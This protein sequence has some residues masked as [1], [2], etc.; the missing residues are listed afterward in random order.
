[1]SRRAFGNLARNSLTVAPPLLHRNVPRPAFTSRPLTTA[2]SLPL[3]ILTNV[4]VPQ[5][6]PRDKLIAMKTQDLQ[7]SLSR[8]ANHARVWSYY[9]DL[10][11]FLGLD[12]LPVEIHQLVLRKCVPPS[13]AIRV[14]SAKQY[15][16][17]YYPESPHLYED[18]LQTVIRNIRASDAPPDLEDY[19]FVLEQFA[20]VGHFTGSRTILKEIAYMGL[21]PRTKTYGLCLQALAHR[22][23]LPCAEDLRPRLFS[24]IV[25]MC[26]DLVDDMTKK[27]TPFTSV[28]L[29]LAIRILRETADEAGFDRLIKLGYGFDLSFPDRLPLEF[30]GASTPAEGEEADVGHPSPQ[31]LSTAA[32][33]TIVDTLGRARRISKMVLAFEVLS[34]PLPQ[35]LPSS[36][37]SFDEEDEDDAFYPPSTQPVLPYP[38]PHA[39]PNTITLNLMVKYASRAENATLARHYILHALQYDRA[40]DRRLR[41]NVMWDSVDTIVSPQFSM[42]RLTL[43]PAFGRANREKDME[44]LRFTLK[45]CKRILRR[46]RADVLYY[47]EWKAKRFDTETGPDDSGVAEE[48]EQVESISLE[49]ES[50]LTT[51]ASTD[52]IPPEGDHVKS[53][54]SA[55]FTPSSSAKG[56]EPRASDK[57]VFDVD[58]DAPAVQAPRPPKIFDIGLHLSILERDIAELR[59]LESHM[60]DILGRTTQRIKERLGRRVWADK[61]IFLASENDRMRVS[62]PF[63]RENV[64]YRAPATKKGQSRRPRVVSPHMSGGAGRY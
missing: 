36:R 46:K 9:T 20:A 1:M 3:P 28:N 16:A 26:Q 17:R 31:P 62:R 11:D 49:E 5:L 34:Q 22:L 63:W 59:E 21:E 33:N 4:S 14:A 54:T 6:S 2:P 41:H 57:S 38:L 45:A 29:D 43:L 47:T 37:T 53:S 35:P 58:L 64:R 13:A 23:A 15:R 39:K 24:S 50:A 18:R 52:G 10:Q 25:Q 40:E 44:L 32:L 8:D 61:S 42:N 55:F 19:H 56:L 27:R 48:P 30:Q 51:D 7:E 12:Q 60:E